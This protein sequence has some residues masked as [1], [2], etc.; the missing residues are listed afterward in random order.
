MR[1]G[2]S[3]KRIVGKADWGLLHDLAFRWFDMGLVIAWGHKTVPI[4][5]WRLLDGVSRLMHFN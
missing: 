3:R 2:L 5:P 4:Y 1:M